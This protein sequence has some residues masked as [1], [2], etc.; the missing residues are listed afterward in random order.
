MISLKSIIDFSSTSG[1]ISEAD[2]AVS[3]KASEERGD[4]S[5]YISFLIILPP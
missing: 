1:I 4:N 3:Q 2:I 5:S